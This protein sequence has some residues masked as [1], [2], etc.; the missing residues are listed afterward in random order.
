MARTREQVA[1]LI[2]SMID[3]FGED[4][5]FINNGFCAGFA[6]GL[7]KALGPE[8]RVVHSLSQYRDGT[9]PGHWWVEYNGLH[10]DAETPEGVETP[11]EMQYHR[12]MRA[13]ADSPED[14]DE[15]EAVFLALGHEPIFYGPASQ[16]NPGPNRTPLTP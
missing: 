5:W 6:S 16:D 11:K 2:R 3:N 9:F 13:I 7:C 4:A 1:D 8:A 10:F 14:M 12:R 15:A